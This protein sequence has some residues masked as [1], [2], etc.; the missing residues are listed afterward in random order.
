MFTAVEGVGAF[1]SIPLICTARAREPASRR[2][3]R[4]DRAPHDD[5]S[6]LMNR[7]SRRDEING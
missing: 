4:R 3:F 5:A 6:S 2:P 7:G 1:V